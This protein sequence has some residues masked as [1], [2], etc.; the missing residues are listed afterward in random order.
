MSDFLKSYEDNKL[1]I[2]IVIWLFVSLMW[3]FLNRKKT[4]K[5]K[6]E[7]LDSLIWLVTVILIA[8][9]LFL[10]FVNENLKY[11]IIGVILS[12]GALTSG[13]INIKYKRTLKDSE[14]YNNGILFVFVAVW[15]FFTL[16]YIT[17]FK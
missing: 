7:R 6:L 17:L 15:V 3:V 14:S 2:F 4:K 12:L 9:I 8:I 10:P 5:G 1:T 16:L 11:T 13:I